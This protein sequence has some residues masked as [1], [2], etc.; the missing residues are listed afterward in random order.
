MRS[1][2]LRLVVASILVCVAAA[3]RR[4]AMEGICSYGQ[5]GQGT[6]KGKRGTGS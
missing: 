1:A 5:V 3:V 6:F 2:R 4:P